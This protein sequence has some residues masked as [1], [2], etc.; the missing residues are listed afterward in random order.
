MGLRGPAPQPTEL[1]LLRGN[2]GKRPILPDLF[3][4]DKE[5]P[6]CPAHIIGPAREH[7]DYV[8][9]E[10]NRYGMLART[11]MGQLALLCT[12]WARYIEAEEMIAMAAAQAPASKGWLQKRE[13]AAG[14]TVAPW[15]RVSRDAIDQYTRL[16]QKFGLS[17]ADRVRVQASAGAAK[18]IES[19]DKGP[20]PAGWEMFKAR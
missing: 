11:D 2:P 5:A 16:A 19:E 15:L 12:V 13:G 1:K 20:T 10:L 18:A 9:A 17:P 8:C 14:L 7:W 4:P 6:P 3:S